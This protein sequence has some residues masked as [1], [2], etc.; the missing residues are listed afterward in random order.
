MYADVRC[1]INRL[2]G[3]SGILQN[4][5]QLRM[6]PCVRGVSGEPVGLVRAG[7]LSPSSGKADRHESLHQQADVPRLHSNTALRLVCSTSKFISFVDKS[8]FAPL[9]NSFINR[10]ISMFLDNSK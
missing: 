4:V 1:G 8:Y 3:L 9:N 6:D 2:I 10:K 5:R 7:K